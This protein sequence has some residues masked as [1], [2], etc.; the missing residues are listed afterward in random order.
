M[1]VCAV[2]DLKFKLD[3]YKHTVHYAQECERCEFESYRDKLGSIKLFL[4]KDLADAYKKAKTAL[5]DYLP[6]NIKPT[7]FEFCISYSEIE[8]DFFW[9]S[10]SYK[11]SPQRIK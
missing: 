4:A 1:L 3:A 7:D 8:N 6:G 9:G 5:L 10:L 11:T 2:T